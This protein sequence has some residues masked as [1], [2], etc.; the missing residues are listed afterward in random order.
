M[1]VYSPSDDSFLLLDTTLD[2]INKDDFVLDVGT[3]TGIIAEELK[4]RSY[5]VIATDIN[6]ESVNEALSKGIDSIRTNLFDCIDT[7][8]DLIVFNP[9]YL[10]SI[11]QNTSLEKALDGGKTGTEVTKEFLSKVDRILKN[12]GRVLFVASDR[13]DISSIKD[14]ANSKGFSVD[15]VSEK[16]LFFEKLVVFKL[17]YQ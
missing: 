8:F 5:R 16:K 15:I 12:T 10:P 4:K 3:G 9:P 11:N 6:Y 7:Y 1:D 2:E 13:S 17:Q 14:F